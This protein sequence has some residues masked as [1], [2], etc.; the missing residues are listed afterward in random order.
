MKLENASNLAIIQDYLTFMDITSQKPSV[1]L[2]R[3]LERNFG[4]E[5]VYLSIFL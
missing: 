1:K 4:T 5:M 2:E 3:E